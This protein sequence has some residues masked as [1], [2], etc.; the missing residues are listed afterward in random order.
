VCYIIGV[1]H[2][3]PIMENVNESHDKLATPSTNVETLSH[4]LQ[5]E[6]H[7]T[8]KI[9]IIKSCESVSCMVAPYKSGTN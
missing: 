3:R 6:L 8:K 1:S 7:P 2:T 5:T 4:S 9:I